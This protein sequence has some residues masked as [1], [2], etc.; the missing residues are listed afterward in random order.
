[1]SDATGTSSSAQHLT[2]TGILRLGLV[3][4]SLG[5]IVVLMTAAI[6]RVMVVE[7]ALP[8]VIPGLLV[9]LFHGVQVMRPAWGHKSDIAGRRTPWIIGGMA[10]LAI[11]GFLA[12]VGSA[13]VPNSQAEGLGIAALGFLLVGCGAGAAG[14]NVLATLAARVAPKRRAAAATLVWVMMI[15]GFAVTAPLAGHY[16]DPYSGS[17]L[18]MVTGVVCV[19]AFVVS[20]LAVIGVETRSVA[21][22]ATETRSASFRDAFREV[23][24]EPSARQFT[25]FIFVSMLA[26]SAQ[27]LLI[28]PFAGLAFGQT[29]GE[30]TKLAGNLHGGVLCGMILVAICASAI[31]GPRLGNLKFWI[32]GGCLAAAV[33][34][35]LVAAAGLGPSG[36][37][38]LKAAV[39][40]LGFGDGVYAASAIG[41]MM[42]LAGKGAEAREGVRMG[43]W[44]A[45]QA[46]ALGA[47]GLIGAGLVDLAR[48][49]LGSALY[50]YAAVFVIEALAFMAAAALASR[51]ERETPAPV[52]AEG[53]EFENAPTRA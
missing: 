21:R 17:R 45:A 15:V 2:W 32:I 3:Q 43:L 11:G 12:A 49:A 26:Y 41:A 30:T 9:A 27:E 36:P 29:V 4:T 6:N 18:V 16:L 10:V 53:V 7:L 34:L 5:A 51:I 40:A 42:G 39:F 44:G 47:G 23:W 19:S 52:G 20:L 48:L 38:P 35:V 31:G 14:T 25:I 1:M 22:P 37:G 33:A 46:L 24:S 13:H 8:A 28:E 50:A